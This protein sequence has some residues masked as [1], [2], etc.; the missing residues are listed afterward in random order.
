MRRYCYSVTRKLNLQFFFHFSD[1]DKQFEM[2]MCYW[3]FSYG[4]GMVPWN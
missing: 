3:Q 4:V 1:T 2:L